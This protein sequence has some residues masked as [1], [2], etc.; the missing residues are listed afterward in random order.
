MHTRT[1]VHV[2]TEKKIRDIEKHF[3]IMT[4]EFNLTDKS[5][6]IVKMTISK[7]NDVLN[8]QASK[9]HKMLNNQASKEKEKKKTSQFITNNESVSVSISY[10][11]SDKKHIMKL[12]QSDEK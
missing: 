4:L 1:L 9:K 6:I 3:E 5:T 8:N 11:K 2:A 12:N 7:I 10:E